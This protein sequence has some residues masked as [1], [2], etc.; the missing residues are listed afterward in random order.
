MSLK[1]QVESQLLTIQKLIDELRLLRVDVVESMREAEEEF[2][3]KHPEA[4]ERI[5]LQ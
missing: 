2:A 4:Y 3:S 1:K 5:N